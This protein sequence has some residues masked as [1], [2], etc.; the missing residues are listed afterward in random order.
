MLFSKKPESNIAP[1]LALDILDRIHFKKPPDWI[2][3]NYPYNLMCLRH[4]VMAKTTGKLE[5]C[6]NLNLIAKFFGIF[7][8]GTGCTKVYEQCRAEMRADMDKVDFA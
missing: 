1:G 3:F 5:L 4:A 6:S 7:V 8:V 2:H